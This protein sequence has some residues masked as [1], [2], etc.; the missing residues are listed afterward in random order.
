MQQ[1][2]EQWKRNADVPTELVFIG[3][4]SI[5]E[6]AGK[7]CSAITLNLLLC[8]GVLVE[9]QSGKWELAEDYSKRQIYLV[10]NAKTVENI[11]KFVRDM[12]D[13]RIMFWHNHPIIA[14]LFWVV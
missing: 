10:G 5:N 4:V 13:R 12:Q 9:G 1:D 2:S 3:L 7:E 14:S 11:V 6:S 8:A